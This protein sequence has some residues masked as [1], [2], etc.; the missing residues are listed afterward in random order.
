MRI[1]STRRRRITAL[2]VVICLA[3][4]GTALAAWFLM[5][6]GQGGVRVGSLSPVSISSG[7]PSTSLYP[8]NDGSATFTIVNPNGALVIDSITNG[9]GT[10]AADSSCPT[11]ANFLS[12]NALS[13]LS[14]PVPA[15]TSTV[16]V[17][18]AFHLSSGT[19]DSC[20]GAS[21]SK[22]INVHLA[23]P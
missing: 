14:I 9:D 6:H 10:S 11:I 13:G 4:A 7:A 16:V 2:A 3:A 8:G 22:D 23:T 5:G 18:G 15:G 1:I 19:P 12:V 20:Q 21:A 17:P